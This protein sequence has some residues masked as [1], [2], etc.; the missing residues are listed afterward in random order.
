MWILQ[1]AEGEHEPAIVDR[2]AVPGALDK[3]TC[4]IRNESMKAAEKCLIQR[5]HL[6]NQT[7]L[8]PCRLCMSDNFALLRLGF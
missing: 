2:S 3:P 5:P 4:F 6:I 8:L 1:V 7:S